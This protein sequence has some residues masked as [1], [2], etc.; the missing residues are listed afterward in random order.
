VDRMDQGSRLVAHDPRHEPSQDDRVADRLFFDF[1]PVIPGKRSY[2]SAASLEGPHSI[3][4]V[5]RRH[6]DFKVLSATYRV[7]GVHAPAGV[8]RGE[9]GERT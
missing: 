1:L 2:H 9:A 8:Q 7:W 6:V 4:A 3:A 5:G